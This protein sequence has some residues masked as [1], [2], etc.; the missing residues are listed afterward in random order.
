MYYQLGKTILICLLSLP[1]LLFLG[2]SDSPEAAGNKLAEKMNENN[3]QYL[4]EHQ[5][6][7]A[8]FVKNFNA[9][10]YATRDEAL[11]D[12]DKRIA[13]LMID[14]QNRKRDIDSEC[15]DASNKYLK[16]NNPSDWHKYNEAFENGIDQ[17]LQAKIEEE[18][19]STYYPI[20]VLNVIRTIIPLK[21]DTKKIIEDLQFE[22]ISEGFPRERCWFSEEERWNLARFDIHDFKIE[23]VLKDNNKD[24]IFIATMRISNDHNAFDARVKISYQL[25][26]DKDWEMEFVNSL[27]VSIVQTHKY[28]DLVSFEIAD[29]GWGG[30]DAL[31]ISN[32]SNVDLLVGV[33]YVAGDKRRRVTVS[34]SPENK[35]Q[36][37]GFLCGGNVTSYEVGFIERL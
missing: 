17:Q 25:P 6:A 36:V 34:V 16:T 37:G 14:Y 28:D 33:D 26:S 19:D 29:D 4:L 30:I 11:T 9:S 1:F 21:P 3:R 27:G 31:F 10:N 2:C 18:M 5:E 12:Y 32:K 24:Y 23:E 22:K 20:A 35:A 15:M 7:E 13:D 8:D